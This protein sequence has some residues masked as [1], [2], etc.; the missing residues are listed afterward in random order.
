MPTLHLVTRSPFSF[1]RTLDFIRN[2]PPCRGECAIGDESL[3][4]AFAEG[5]RAVPVTLRA[6]PS[7]L[8]LDVP[9]GVDTKRIADRVALWLGTDHDLAPFY[10]IAKTDGP[11][12]W[13]IDELHGLHHVAFQSLEDI[14]VYCVMM[15][16]APISMAAAMKRKFL[17]AFG[18]KVTVGDRDLRAIP[19]FDALVQLDGD[20]IGKAIG[21]T[22]KGPAI[23][24]VVRGVAALGEEFLRTAPYAEARDALLAI[25]GVG[26]FSAAAILLRGL[27]RMD[28]LAGHV[29]EPEGKQVYG[30]AFDIDEINRRYGKHVGYW[31]YYLKSGV[32]RRAR[33]AA[34]G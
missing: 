22:L 18:W 29:G 5:G 9:A 19:T 33:A 7:G 31:A 26:P 30:S 24:K 15:Q 13:L 25:P 3:T 6:T 8:S 2:F 4:V 32:G 28:E 12:R 11:M 17:D 16:R 27:G 21:H 34:K 23:A 10:A 1:V 14:A 20:A